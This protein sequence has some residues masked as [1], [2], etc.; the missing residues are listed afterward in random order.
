[1]HEKDPLD[2]TSKGQSKGV[3]YVTFAIREDAESVVKSYEESSGEQLK[4]DG[5]VV[6]VK[7]A[8]RKVSH[9]RP[10]I[11]LSL[12]SQCIANSNS[13]PRGCML[14]H[15]YLP[16]HLPNPPRR[17]PGILNRIL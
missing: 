2:A 13:L 3:G 17:N 8:D 4:I 11:S 15:Q 14:K 10:Y 12:G 5:R 6:R 9:T 1:V 16:S 7:W